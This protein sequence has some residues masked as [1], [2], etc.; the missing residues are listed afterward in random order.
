LP[1]DKLEQKKQN[2]KAGPEPKSGL[3]QAFS[4]Q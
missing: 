3:R 2:K 4:Y 1:T